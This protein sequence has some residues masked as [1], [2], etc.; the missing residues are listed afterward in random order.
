M[1]RGIP[2]LVVSVPT[3][4]LADSLQPELDDVEMLVWDMESPAPRDALDIVVPPYMSMSTV[5]PR[6]AEVRTRLVQSQSIGYEG[7]EQHLPPGHV[8]ANASSV[9]ETSTAELALALSLA[10]QRRIPTYVRAQDEHRWAPEFSQSLADRRILLLGYG[11]VGKAVAARL[12]PFEV[13]LTV[14]AS[15]ARIEDGMPVHSVDE[16]PGLLPSAEILLVTLPGGESTK[17]IVDDAVLSALPD[18]ALVVNVGR[19]PLIDTDALVDH[20]RRG[21]IRSALDVTDPEPLPEDHPLWSLPGSLVVPHIGG[22]SSA[23]KPRTVRLIRTQIDRM[24][25]GEPPLNVVYKS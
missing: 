1:N 16:L 10:A 2:K 9:H 5:I 20:V 13:E 14:V 17:H 23:M 11:G 24:L 6:L 4:E 8:F 25:A 22:A 3:Q 21:R 15:R 19:G 18:G 7:I 12:A